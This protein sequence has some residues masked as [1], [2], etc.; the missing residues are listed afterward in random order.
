MPGRRAVWSDI[1]RATR[2]LLAPHIV[3][4][5]L[6]LQLAFAAGVVVVS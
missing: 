2:A 6:G 5:A 4:L 3:R 1:A